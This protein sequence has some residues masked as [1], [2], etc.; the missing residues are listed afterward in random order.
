MQELKHT[1]AREQPHIN[2]LLEKC[3][4]ELPPLAR[5]VAAHVLEAGGKRLRPLLTLLTGRALGCTHDDLYTL[6]AAVEMLHAATLLHDD[7]LDDAPVRRGKPAAHTLFGVTPVILAGDALLA[8]ALLM[9][10]SLGDARLTSCISEA[11]MRTAEGEMAEFAN[12]RN[13]AMPH[14][15]YLG[16]ISGKT[17]WM[18]RASCELGALK[19]GADT[20]VV[21]AA[22]R[23]GMELGIAFQMVDDA[24]DF[25]PEQKTGKPTGGDVKEG[26]VTPP[27][28]MYFANLSAHLPGEQGDM[29]RKR[30]CDGSLTPDDIAAISACIYEQGYA[31]ATRDLA[32]AHLQKAAAALSLLPEGPECAM[33]RQMALY[34]RQREH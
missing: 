31:K 13:I 24:L 8:K 17:A 26:K 20:N 1:I 6:G 23:F 2:A 5:P 9:V 22:A 25:S 15:V 33:L 28:L 14:A 30:F 11:V 27:L 10:S 34:I 32:D 16:I 29:L 3:L 19:A 21:E 18:L 7:I 4:A 12:L